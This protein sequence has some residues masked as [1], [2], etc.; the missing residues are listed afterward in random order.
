MTSEL[1]FYGGAVQSTDHFDVDDIGDTTYEGPNKNGWCWNKDPPGFYAVIYFDGEKFNIL[2]NPATSGDYNAG[3]SYASGDTPTVFHVFTTTGYLQRVSPVVGAYSFISSDSTSPTASSSY[4]G[5]YY[6]PQQLMYGNKMFLFNK[7]DLDTTDDI[8]HKYVGMSELH[9][10][11]GAIDCETNPTGA[12]FTR[13]CI[14]KEDRV[15]FISTDSTIGGVYNPYYPNL[16]T[17]KKI[18]REERQG[19]NYP[20]E[21]S[22]F[23]SETLRHQIVLDYGVNTLFHYDS[24]ASIYKFHPPAEAKKYNYVAECS[25]RGIC[26]TGSGLCQCFPGYTGDACDTQNAL[27]K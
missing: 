25:N 26:D 15:M 13:D 4:A 21:R 8:I 19:S 18:G 11:L 5:K 22:D 10:Y 24:Y 14:N 12:N 7:G 23:N 3:Q 17:V 20:G 1:T 2:T 16:Y 9:P 27:A 6:P